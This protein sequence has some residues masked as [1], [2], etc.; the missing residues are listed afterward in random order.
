MKPPCPTTPHKRLDS[1]WDRV[2]KTPKSSH[3]K[4][5]TVVETSHKRPPLV[6][7]TPTTLTCSAAERCF[8]PNPQLQSR[9]HTQGTTGIFSQA[10]ESIEVSQQLPL[11]R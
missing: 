5:Y 9:L 2:S 8:K 11:S 4:S 10:M 6:Q 3:S 1:L 7:A